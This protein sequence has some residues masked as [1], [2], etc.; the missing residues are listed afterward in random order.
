MITDAEMK[1]VLSVKNVSRKF[2]KGLKYSML[3]GMEDLF[4]SF[5]RSWL[6]TGR[7]RKG[8]F[9][10][11]KDV[12]FELHK[13]QVL[14][15]IG[16]NGCGKTTLLRLIAGILPPDEGEIVIE[17][18][19]A[20]LISLG[21][22]FHPLMT[23]REN[24][25]LSGTVL[26]MS[27]KEIDAKLGSIISFSELGD[28]IDMPISHYSSGMKVRLGFSIAIAVE[29][30]ILL[31]DEVL[32]VGDQGFKAKCYHEMDKLSKSTAIIL[33]SHSMSKISRVCTQAMVLVRGLSQHHGADVRAGIDC[34]YSQCGVEKESVSG[35]GN[36]VIHHVALSSGVRCEAEGQ[37]FVLEHREDLDLDIAF[38]LDPS[39]K[40]AVMKLYILDQ[41][42]DEMC[43]IFSSKDGFYID[44]DSQMIKVRIRIP[45][46]QLSP[47]LYY[48]TILLRDPE[49]KTV[50]VKAHAV[51][52][53]RV[54]GGFKSTAPFHL[55]AE[56]SY[57]REPRQARLQAAVQDEATAQ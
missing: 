55:S 40:R 42:F 17:G 36:A 24:I 2:S 51:K 29:P 47:G 30:D 28:F 49:E 39:V 23:G 53:F 5:F 33:V 44:N 15:I 7:L 11:L 4:R 57:L 22:G 8:E 37:D 35:T 13:G 3:H 56:W 43:S 14:G 41:E 48:L 16:P 1:P 45:S 9:W 46:I 32:A 21:A 19:V 12:S 20:S 25:Y 52:H 26:G 50:L 38:S 31:L 18:R 34:Y 54:K 6:S 10:A 27:H